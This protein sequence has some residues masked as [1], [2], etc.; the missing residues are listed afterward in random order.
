MV[1][2]PCLALSGLKPK[3]DRESIRDSSDEGD[4]DDEDD[5]GD[6][7]DYGDEDDYGD[8]GDD[9]D[10]FARCNPYDPCTFAAL[11]P[12]IEISSK[13]QARSPECEAERDTDEGGPIT[14]DSVFWRDWKSPETEDV[15]NAEM[16]SED[17]GPMKS[18]L[19]LAILRTCRQV[20]TEASQVFYAMAELVITPE[21]LVDLH[22]EDEIIERNPRM[23]TRP[24]F[25]RHFQHA[26]YKIFESLGLNSLLDFAAFMRIERICF[27]A[28]YNFLFTNDSP[29]LYV[30][31]DFHADPNTEASLIKFM[32]KTRTVENLVSLLATLPRLRQLNLR[33]VLEVK[34][35]MHLLSDEEIDEVGSLNFIQKMDVANERAT[36]LFIECG[37]LNPLGTLSNVQN[38]DLQVRTELL[39]LVG[40]GETEY[41]VLKPRHAKIAQNLKEAIEHNW[42]ARSSIH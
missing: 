39:T 33:L 42:T 14:K 2:N 10:P 8:E 9:S 19:A 23:F 21:D 5:Y 36:E 26:D 20:Y 30:C 3:T 4:Y 38:F 40:C 34:N 22:D 31:R 1:A 25:M 16:E 41:M 28:Y 27:D 29:A 13:E 35:Q 24:I 11:F 17:N 7:G 6:E 15:P 12:H 18:G 37:I 32:K